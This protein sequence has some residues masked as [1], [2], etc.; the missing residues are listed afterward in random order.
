MLIADS[1][2]MFWGQLLGRY[3]NTRTSDAHTDQVS[4]KKG[5]F[6]KTPSASPPKRSLE[7]GVRRH[8]SILF[9]I[10]NK[11]SV[12]FWPV[13]TSIYLHLFIGGFVLQQAAS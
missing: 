9:V 11:W 4:I 1:V 7:Q 13:A 2:A 6:V 10:A 8:H 12:V 3:A 5:D